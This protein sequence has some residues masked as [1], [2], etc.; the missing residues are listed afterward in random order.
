[1]SAS[2]T[3]LLGLIAWTMILTLGLLTARTAAMLK[4]HPVNT[5]TQDGNELAAISQR[6]TR[7]HGNSLEWLAIPVGL[8]AYAIATGQ[9]AITDGLAMIFLGARV[10]QSIVH[11]IS[12]STPAVLLR[13]TFFTV[14]VVISIIWLVKLLGVA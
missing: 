3:C 12:T 2:A 10:L 7:A 13:A 11:V 4:G 1:M 5:F 14:H 6:V 8:L 9:T